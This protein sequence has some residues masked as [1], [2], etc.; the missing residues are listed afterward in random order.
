MEKES[1]Y[2]AREMYRQVDLSRSNSLGY[3]LV[4][5]DRIG[6]YEEDREVISF[7]PKHKSWPNEVWFDSED[8]IVETFYENEEWHVYVYTHEGQL[9]GTADMVYGPDFFFEPDIDYLFREDQ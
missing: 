1:E 7:K 6:V 4:Y 3:Y 8:R 2:E 5:L 9:L